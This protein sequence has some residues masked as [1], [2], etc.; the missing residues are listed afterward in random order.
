MSVLQQ[1]YDSEINFS[2]S[3]FFDD[4]FKVQLGD[5]LNGIRA[6]AQVRTIAEADVWLTQAVLHHYPTS[7]FASAVLAAI[8]T[9][10]GS[11]AE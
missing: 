2:I 6:E 4:G 1:L 5:P 8:A 10:S 7:R 3:A 9:K 11:R